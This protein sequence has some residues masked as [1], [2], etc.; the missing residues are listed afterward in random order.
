MSI[1]SQQYAN[2]KSYAP[3]LSPAWLGRGGRKRPRSHACACA[4]LSHQDA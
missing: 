2:P 4:W 1:T 3:V